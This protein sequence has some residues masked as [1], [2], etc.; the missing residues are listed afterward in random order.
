MESHVSSRSGLP[1]EPVRCIADRWTCHGQQYLAGLISNF[2]V[3]CFGATMGWA[4]FD[5]QPSSESARTFIVG[6]S[7]RQWTNSLLPLGAAC[8]CMPMGVMMK[9]HGSRGLMIFQLLPYTCGWLLVI[10][11]RNVYM[12]YVGRYLLGI[13]GAALCVAVP[14]YNVE[15]SQLKARGLMGSMFYGAIVYGIVFANIL[16]HFLGEQLVNIIVLSMALL[17]CS[18]KILPQSPAFYILHGKLGHARAALHWLHGNEAID[19]EAL[20]AEMIMPTEIEEE[21]THKYLCGHK[22]AQLN[23]PRASVMLLLY[24][25]SGGV[26]ICG[27]L[28]D[29]LLPFS[30]V[31]HKYEWIV[32]LAMILGHL[33]CFLLV[34]RIGRR[35]ILVLSAVFMFLASLYLCTWFQWLTHTKWNFQPLT[36]LFLFIASFSFGMG[37]VSWILYVEL[38]IEPSRAL[39]CSFAATLGW[40]TAS[41]MVFVYANNLYL[42]TVFYLMLLVCFVTL[43]FVVIFIPETKGLTS[44]QIQILLSHRSLGDTHSTD[45][46]F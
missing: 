38:I 14:V 46:S 5:D 37:P 22:Y 42:Q 28:R 45:S 24:Q 17:N 36:A 41:A 6:K 10:F 35:V 16:E 30:S 27:F 11:A 40:L 1:C 18:V 31:F 8:F 39:G 20:T 3:F 44:L 23:V 32:W 21:H 15:I 4:L 7:S 34:D 25:L 9:K 12:V 19:I 26:V 43:I 29:I 13:C 2:G 33:I